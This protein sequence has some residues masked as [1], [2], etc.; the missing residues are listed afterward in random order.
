MASKM[1]LCL[2]PQT[3]EHVVLDGKRE[4][5]DVNKLRILRLGDHLDYP[6][7]TN[8]ITNVFIRGR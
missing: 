6:G 5:A 7:R 8:I 1:Y 4:F 2:N 3:Y